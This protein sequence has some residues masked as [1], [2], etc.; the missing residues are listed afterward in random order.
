MAT[1]T[2][3]ETG[4]RQMEDGPGPD[5][6]TE[7]PAQGWKATLKRTFGEFKR[8]RASMTA[9]GIAF[10]WFLA[11]FPM[12]IA[13][14]GILAL[15]GAP[16]STISGIEGGV[17]NVLPGSAA[18]VLTGAISNASSTAAH[19]AGLTAVVVGI[20]LALWSASSG[21]AAVQVGLGVAY[22]VPED[23]TFVKKRAMSLLLIGI[24]LVLGGVA[25]ALLVFGRPIGDAIDNALPLGGGFA[26]VWTVVRWALTILAVLT[27][28]AVFYALG[29]NRKTPSWTWLTPG[30]LVAVVIWLAASVGFSFYVSN[31]GGTY[32]KTYGSLAGVIVLVLWLYL[33]AIALM[34]G[35]E[36]N[37]ELEREKALRDR[38]VAPTPESAEEGE[39]L[40]DAT[41]GQPP[42]E[43]GVR[44][45]GRR[46]RRASRGGAPAEA[47]VQPVTGCSSPGGG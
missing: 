21:M 12:L 13:A 27:L 28:F 35:A 29:P 42:L 15:V 37:G 25:T 16:Q 7:L 6:P 26:V 30:G 19:A 33:T 47:L 45:K 9:A 18:N 31:F 22:D 39:A 1:A 4:V 43:R 38:G 41:N 10:Y 46:A 40:T 3:R 44:P 20:A 17:R 32:G 14:V 2:R 23:R 36:L 34:V 11:L 8:D 5:S 24:A